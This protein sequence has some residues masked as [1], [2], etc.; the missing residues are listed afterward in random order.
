MSPK[1]LFS[2]FV[3]KM[4]RFVS[5]DAGLVAGLLGIGIYLAIARRHWTAALFLVLGAAWIISVVIRM[6]FRRPD[7]R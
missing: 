6:R 5:F 4:P 1:I 2:R 7:R 3:E